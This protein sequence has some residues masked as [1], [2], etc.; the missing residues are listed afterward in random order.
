MKPLTSLD[1]SPEPAPWGRRDSKEFRERLK[2]MSMIGIE[3]QA[4]VKRVAEQLFSQKP[5]W[6]TFYRETLGL[7]GIVR[8]AF[9]SRETLAAFEQSE[10]YEQILQLLTR[11][12]AEDAIAADGEEPTRV[13]T[14][15]LPK[16]LHETLREEAH[17]HRTS[18][19]KLCISKLLQLIE[20]D[21]VPAES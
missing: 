11:L 21:K 8:H 14:V 12:R 7:R 5:D 2:E 13:I 6:V 19:N 20:N 17:E 10:A 4:E 9:P 18:M 15:R 16:S 1:D 3:K